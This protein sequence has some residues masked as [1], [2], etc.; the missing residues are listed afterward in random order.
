MAGEPADAFYQKE[1]SRNGP[2]VLVFADITT[3]FLEPRFSIVFGLPTIR[4]QRLTTDTG[5]TQC[6]PREMANQPASFQ[7]LVLARYKHRWY[8]N[9]D[10]A[11]V[12]EANASAW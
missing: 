10:P 7:T 12:I 11:V 4:D 8:R 1:I 3:D 2:E 9:P 6:L 5:P